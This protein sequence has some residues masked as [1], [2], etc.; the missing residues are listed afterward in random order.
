MKQKRFSNPINVNIL[1]SD[2][3]EKKNCH[4]L[5]QS[6]KENYEKIFNNIIE[7][8]FKTTQDGKLLTVNPALAKMYGYSSPEEMISIINDFGRQ[9][10]KSHID[11]EKFIETIKKQESVKDFEVQAKKKNGDIFWVSVNAYGVFDSNKKLLYF[12]GTNIDITER[13][14]AEKQAA[15]HKM[16]IIQAD[17]MSTLGVLVSGVAHEINNP[18]NSIAL[19]A[20]V[21]RKAW[22]CVFPILDKYCLEPGNEIKIGAMNY[23]DFTNNF[24]RLMDGIDEGSTRIKR[25]VSELKEYALPDAYNGD[26]VISINNVTQ[27][28][29]KLMGPMVRKKTKK[30]SMQLS[31]EPLMFKGSFQKIEQVI[32]NLLQNA[33]D[34]LVSNKQAIRLSTANSGKKNIEIRITDEGCGIAPEN[35]QKIFDPFFTTKRAKGGTGLGLSVSMNIVKEHDG[36]LKFES[37]QEKGTTATLILPKANK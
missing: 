32:I 33:C 16:Q 5:D 2:H 22:E 8:I 31:A 29:I 26:Q 35:M 19:S 30:F 21:L 18:N 14:Q 36:E 4:F 7:G 27:S 25:I 23:K 11:R 24:N 17:K 3:S 13:K 9:G 15:M 12:E 34:A 6:S 1:S 20:A 28:A 37:D 10:Y